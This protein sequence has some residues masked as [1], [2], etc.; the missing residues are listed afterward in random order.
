MIKLYEPSP[1]RVA[2]Q[3]FEERVLREKRTYHQNTNLINVAIGNVSL[4]T[5]PKLLARLKQVSD[6]ELLKGIWRYSSTSGHFRANKS[7]SNI[8]RSFLSNNKN[9]KLF[10]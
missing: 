7:F 8:I 5:H 4:S 2:Q 6:P 1:V 10:S 9:P 3:L